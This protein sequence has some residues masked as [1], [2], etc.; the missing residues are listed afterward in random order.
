[1]TTVVSFPRKFRHPLPADAPTRG[2]EIDVYI[3][4]E[5]GLWQVLECDDGGGSMATFSSRSAA[6]AAGIE[7][8]RF[9]CG[10]LRV[11]NSSI[12]DEDER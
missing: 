9:R 6:L 7:W 3:Y 4:P 12:Y 11:Q 8:L 5:E 10:T 2:R 1:M